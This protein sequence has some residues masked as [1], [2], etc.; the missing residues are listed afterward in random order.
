MSLAFGESWNY[1]DKGANQ[2]SELDPKWKVCQIGEFQSPIDIQTKKIIKE[3]IDLEFAYTSPSKRIINN[4]HTLQVEYKKGNSIKWMGETYNLVQFHLHTPS[5]NKINSKGFPLEAHFVHENKS[6]KLL[7]VAM[8]FKEGNPNET[9]QA[10]VDALPLKKDEEKKFQ[11]KV[12]PF[13][14][15]AFYSFKGSLTTPPCSEDV[16]WIVMKQPFQASKEQILA[17]HQVMGD[18]A[19]NTQNLANRTIYETR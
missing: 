10:I 2:W 19:R 17:L 6:G 1:S 9:I 3:K 15:L 18:N 14:K 5:E 7:V 12:N 8:L 13:E 16:Q 4:G 11:I